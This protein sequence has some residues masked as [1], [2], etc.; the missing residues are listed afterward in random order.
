M[1]FTKFLACSYL[2]GKA[3]VYVLFFVC[4]FFAVLLLMRIERIE[5]DALRS[6]AL[7]SVVA[8]L[9]IAAAVALR[10]ATATLTRSDGATLR[11]EETE[12]PEIQEMRLK[13][14]L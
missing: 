9:M 6:T 3:N 14:D 10:W 12:P 7:Y 4:V 13:R 5:R 1:A 8:A 2:P 11:F